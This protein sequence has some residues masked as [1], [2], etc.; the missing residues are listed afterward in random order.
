MKVAIPYRLIDHKLYVGF[1]LSTLPLILIS[2]EFSD[3]F[4]RVGVVRENQNFDLKVFCWPHQT[5][6]RRQFLAFFVRCGGR[7]GCRRR[8]MNPQ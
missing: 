1:S 2:A 3:E 6:F 8:K 5:E 7:F 4:I